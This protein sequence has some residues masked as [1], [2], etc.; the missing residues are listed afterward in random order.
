MTRAEYS[1]GEFL[2]YTHSITFGS[3][4]RSIPRLELARYEK[5]TI[6][7]CLNLTIPHL[8]R[9]KTKFKKSTFILERKNVV[10]L[11]IRY[12]K[13]SHLINTSHVVKIWKHRVS[14]IK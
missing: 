4:L 10:V 9:N 6:T 7:L 1:V 11:S 13:Y 12:K 5:L 14:L 8:N 2:I 3:C